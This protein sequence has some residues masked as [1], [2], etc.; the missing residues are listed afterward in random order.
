MI[1]FQKKVIYWLT[2]ELPNVI[3][4]KSKFINFDQNFEPGNYFVEFPNGS[5][6]NNIVL[7][8][9][10]ACIYLW[11]TNRHICRCILNALYIP[12]FKQSIFS[13]QAATKNSAHISFEWDNS[14]LIYPNGAVFNIT[15]RGCLYY[16]KNIVSAKNATYDLHTW[17]KILSHCNK[18]D[19]KS[20]PTY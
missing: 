4:D 15:Q 17:H 5:R 10:N 14:Q 12:T 3:T 20:Y 11:N 13:V 1:L 6:V 7:K 2:V 16:L 9:V 19:I 18:S 8:R